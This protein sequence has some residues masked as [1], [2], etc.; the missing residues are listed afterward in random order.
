MFTP[1]STLSEGFL[2]IGFNFKS[3][4]VL[5]TYA[6]KT[7]LLHFIFDCILHFHNSVIDTVDDNTG[8]RGKLNSSIDATNQTLSQSKHYN[9]LYLN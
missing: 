4:I 9:S 8:V 7:E 3:I 1:S 5:K 6:F 2:N